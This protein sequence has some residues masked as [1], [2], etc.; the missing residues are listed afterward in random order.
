MSRPLIPPTTHLAEVLPKAL[1]KK[2]LADEE[3]VTVA[4]L[5]AIVPRKYRVRGQTDE[6]T[7][8]TDG[9]PIG[10]AGTVTRVAD[11]FSGGR[12]PKV[13][14]VFVDVQTPEGPRT[15][16]FFNMPWMVK[17][18]SR[19]QEV[20]VIGIAKL[21]QGKITCVN[22]TFRLATGMRDV[23]AADRD[24]DAEAAGRAG[25]RN[26]AI[27]LLDLADE[28]LV[29]RGEAPLL[30]RPMLPVYPATKKVSAWELLAAVAIVLGITEP[31]PETLPASER[32]RYRLIERQH[33]A[34]A[35]HFPTDHAEVAAAR[36]RL[37]FDVALSVHLRL[38]QRR[39]RFEAGQ[40]PPSAPVAGGI[41][42]RLLERLP[43][44]LTGGQQRVLA[45]IGADISQPGPTAR[46]LQG[47]V[48][49]GKTVVALLAMC[50]VIDAG[51][52]CAM[53]APTE[54][55]AAQHERALRG[56][57]GDIAAPP[58]TAAGTLFAQPDAE[59]RVRVALVTGSM[60]TGRRREVLL[61]VVT[62]E[63]DIVVGTHALLEDTVDFYD[64][65]LA[66]VDEQHRFGVEQR[67]VLRRKR[68]DGAMPHMLAMTATPI[69]RT[70][71]MMAF[72]DMRTSTLTELPAGR[73]EISTHV[74][75]L[76]V[77]GRDVDKWVAR[78]YDRVREE[79][80]AGGRAFVVA[81]RIDSDT[82]TD[83][84][85]DR[86]QSEVGDKRQVVKHPAAKAGLGLEEFAHR[87][88]DHELSGLRIG[89]VHGRMPSA[90]K[91]AVMT[92]FAA[93][94]LDVLVAT[95]VIE[96]GVD[97]PEATI[98]VVHDADRFGIS[99]LHQLRGRV[100]RGTKPGVCLLVTSVEP[101]SLAHERLE[102][103]AA[104]H[105]GFAL[106]RRDLE[107][108]GEG[109]VFGARQS[110]GMGYRR[111]LSVVADE[112]LIVE[113]GE[114]A[115]EILAADPELEH[116]PQLAAE[117]EEFGAADYLDRT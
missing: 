13:K 21:R 32:A 86:L 104:T 34:T 52:Q 62:G 72:G 68:T 95:T 17:K 27:D 22:P 54:V 81:P 83:A 43:Y 3:L 84:Q 6:A 38:G 92:E 16:V 110:G 67:E 103:V 40:A 36:R 88:Q 113:A 114:L 76:G 11:N 18:F 42:D 109:D 105:D 96:V 74:V 44:Q 2:L 108:R 115:V 47:D 50:Q 24:A 15:A 33:A 4:S 117:I 90:D 77:P 70:I 106:S 1:A 48:G 107:L 19:G 82:L 73:K 23:L 51:R 112:D 45:E 102:A 5:L 64:L 100:G 37:K 99:Q 49:S 75:Q 65:G 111:I 98:M 25:G 63:V 10:F 46:L 94:D 55:L 20:D 28:H 9:D 26:A 30:E 59:R 101:G 71:A 53:L 89:V 58:G 35:I 97:V 8:I 39:L 7:G 41:R 66:V 29:S 78:V 80:L 61:G 12:F 56:L 60:S 57:L 69:P 116:L 93:G 14:A 79:V 91:D 85:L 31:V 87:L